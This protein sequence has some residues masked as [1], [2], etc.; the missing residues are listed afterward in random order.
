M[1]RN[2]EQSVASLE[3]SANPPTWV[4]EVLIPLVQNIVG[5]V[6]VT[7][8]GIIGVRAF[9]GEITVQAVTWCALVGGALACTMTVTRFFGD[10]LGLFKIAYD[11]G[12]NSRNHDLDVLNKKLYAT[13]AA[14]EAAGQP[15]SAG[16]IVKRVHIG[17]IAV[18][19]ARTI[20]QVAYAGGNY[21]RR[22]MSD[23][24]GEKDWGRAVR[25]LQVVNV[26]DRETYG[27]RNDVA[28]N[29]NEAMKLI[30]RVERE[31]VPL[32]ANNAFVPGWW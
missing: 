27:L 30:D 6:A 31:D 32:L 4:S 18:R 8:L 12:R 25:L 14:L 15:N 24:M 2:I 20:A 16:V 26:L 22:A 5:G 19:N 1:D 28:P 10:D 13:Q 17:Q 7:G 29:V 21:R 3:G 11:A 9:T 23:K